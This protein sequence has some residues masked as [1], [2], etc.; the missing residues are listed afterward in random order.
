[1]QLV[2]SRTPARPAAESSIALKAARARV[3]LMR[4]KLLDSR[5]ALY[6][7]RPPR[8]MSVAFAVYPE[9]GR[10]FGVYRLALPVRPHGLGAET[11]VPPG[12]RVGES[13]GSLLTA[14]ELAINL[15]RT[16]RKAAS[17]ADRRAVVAN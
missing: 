14:V 10:R 17:I 16:Y 12:R 15:A 13:Q 7:A 1:M 2:S 9:D 5:S 11:S 4:M 3:R 8:D 6:L